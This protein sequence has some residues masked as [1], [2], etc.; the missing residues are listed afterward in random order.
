MITTDHKFS[1]NKKNSILGA[2]QDD[3]DLIASAS[4]YDPFKVLGNQT[5][6][7]DQFLVIYSPETKKITLTKNQIPTSRL[8]QSDFFI[9]T[10]N[11]DE[12]DEHYLIN[13]TDN[14]N[15]IISY[16]DPYSFKPQLSDFDLHLLFDLSQD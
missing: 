12:I 4:H 11:V 15:S 10:Q 9:C 6:H 13:R 1:D 14:T 8:L 2:I 5:F 16:F 3:L 7:R